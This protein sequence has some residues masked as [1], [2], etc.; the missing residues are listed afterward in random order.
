M[1]KNVPV[2]WETQVWSLGLDDP[3]EEGTAILSCIFAWRTPWTEE[4]GGLQSIR[5]QRDGHDQ[6]E[7]ACMHIKQI[8]SKDLQYG[9]RNYTQYFVITYK[10]KESEKEYI[11]IHIYIYTHTHTYTPESLWCKP[12]ANTTLQ[13]S[14]TSI[15]KN[16]KNRKAHRWGVPHI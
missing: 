13:I 8:S 7:W 1:V 15:L 4:P 3:L 11:H 6:S 9:T 10:G 2:V 16:V 12:E 5:V 14:Y